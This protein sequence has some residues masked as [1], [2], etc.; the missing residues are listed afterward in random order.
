MTEETAW[1]GGLWAAADLI[2]PMAVRVAATLRL[3]DHI[4]AG[5][6]TP[7]SLAAATGTHPDTLRR[8]L[9][10]LVTAGLLTRPEPGVYGL[11]DLGEQL[12]DDHPGGIRSW[13]DMTGAIGRAELSFVDL[14]HTVRT[15]EAAYP[16]RYGRPFW[17]DV[18]ADPDRAA[19]FDALMGSRLRD[20]APA[21]A[22]GYPWGTLGH[23]VDVG[24]GDG[25]LLIA[26]LAAHPGLR[27]T[28]LDLPGPA[29]RA[30]AAIDAAGLNDRAD[31]R[32]GSFF[33]ELPPGAGG[34]L[35]SGILHDWDD[36]GA[37]RILRNCAQAAGGRG[38]V[39][40]MEDDVADEPSTEGDLRMLC[41]VNGRERGVT[42]LGDLAAAAGLVVET[43]VPAG[44]R[45]I[46]EM[47]RDTGK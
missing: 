37:T 1:G 5:S 33:D 26:I 12:R 41:Y 43:V 18:A 16:H 45:A 31:A 42:Q 19:S 40:V 11:T 13:L 28:V 32:P 46:V 10:H 14:L 27:G 15:G 17:E 36:A 44:T 38:R 21:V 39:L 23:L 30:R 3:G 9:D 25:T 6:G 24:G 47:R 2:T 8:V 34:Y 20:D 22:T 35:L 4:T 7:E 29:E